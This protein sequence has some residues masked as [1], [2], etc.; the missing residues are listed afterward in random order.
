MRR[1]RPSREE[2]L[3][4]I[5]SHGPAHPRLLGKVLGCELGTVYRYIPKLLA[6]GSIREVGGGVKGD[7]YRYEVNDG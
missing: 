3:R 7:P 6:E 4:A 5:R 1:S 2:L